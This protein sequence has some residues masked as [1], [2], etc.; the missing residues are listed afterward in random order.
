MARGQTSGDGLF[1]DVKSLEIS[2][3]AGHTILPPAPADA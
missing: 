3:F 2:V 1:A